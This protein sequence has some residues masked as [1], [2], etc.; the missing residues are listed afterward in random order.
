M[1]RPRKHRKVK[2]CPA[3]YYFK[4]RAVPLSNLEEVVLEI[5]E[6]ESLRLADFLAL[7]HEKAAE[8]MKISRATF[9]RIVEKAREK[10]VDA[11]L[12][13]KALKISDELPAGLKGDFKCKSCGA[14][15]TGK[16][17]VCNNCKNKLGETNETGCTHNTR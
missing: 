1:P 6:L 13:G 17:K 8:Q 3:A 16:N 12:H 7:S 10:I 5:D 11:I 15:I 4:P 2:C 14:V 9:G